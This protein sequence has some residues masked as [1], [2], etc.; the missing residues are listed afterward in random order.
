MSIDTRRLQ[1]EINILSEPGVDPE[2]RILLEESNLTN[3]KIRFAGPPNSPYQGGV[4]QIDVTIQDGYP[5]KPPV[6]K[7]DTNI[8][9]PNISSQTGVI[10]LDILKDQWSPI[11]TLRTAILSLIALLTAPEPN[12]PQDAEVAS[13]YLKDRATFESTAKYWAEVFSPPL[14]EDLPLVPK[15]LVDQVAE[16]GLPGMEDSVIR[17][18]LLRHRFDPSAA[19]TDL[20]SSLS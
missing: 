2:V 10:C 1:K 20:L 18:A 8:Y 3:F 9:H 11:L 19:A 6:L 14:P 5:F 13:V 17:A 4:Y 12:D 15:T 7:F 16:I